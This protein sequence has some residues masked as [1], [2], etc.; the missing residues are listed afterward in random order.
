MK[1]GTNNVT[2]RKERLNTSAQKEEKTTE[3]QTGSGKIPLMGAGGRAA[4]S[5]GFSSGLLKTSGT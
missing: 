3:A 4:G 2:E 5:E 1:K